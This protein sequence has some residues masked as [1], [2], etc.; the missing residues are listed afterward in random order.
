MHVESTRSLVVAAPTTLVRVCVAAVLTGDWRRRWWRRWRSQPLILLSTAACAFPFATVMAAAGGPPKGDVCLRRGGCGKAPPVGVVAASW[1]PE[2]NDDDDRLFTHFLLKGQPVIVRNASFARASVDVWSPDEFDKLF[3]EEVSFH[4]LLSRNRYVSYHSPDDSSN[5]L[6]GFTP[7]VTYAKLPW[8]KARAVADSLHRKGCVHKPSQKPNASGGIARACKAEYCRIRRHCSAYLFL[9]GQ[10]FQEMVSRSE[11]LGSA[12]RAWNWSWL[13]RVRAAAEWSSPAYGLGTA[14]VVGQE[15]S[16]MTPHFDS[17]GNVVLQV[18]GNKGVVLWPPEDTAGLYPF[19][20][21]HPAK[22]Q[23]MLNPETFPQFG[24]GE[25]FPHHS[26]TRPQRGV[27]TAGDALYLPLSWWHMMWS[28]THLSASVSYWH[29]SRRPGPYSAPPSWLRGAQDK[30]LARY[31]SLLWTYL[32]GIVK[33][34][35]GDTHLDQALVAL[36]RM[37]VPENILGFER[38][39]ERVKELL[40][41]LFKGDPVRAGK[42][43]EALAMGRFGVEHD[44]YV[45]IWYEGDDKTGHDDSSRLVEKQEKGRTEL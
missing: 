34:A 35:V 33:D 29:D 8:V 14:L 43:V 44:R 7:P 24:Q 42:F 12:Y 45:H 19:P 23:A 36:S 6:Y 22:R 31:T 25:S 1:L 21:N 26:S 30:K 40:L 11:E 41:W 20:S 2:I 32:E 37:Q 4:A 18:Y 16:T 15:H 38:A 3:P 17:H 39:L 10:S 13:E 27:L 28:E 9:D 5:E